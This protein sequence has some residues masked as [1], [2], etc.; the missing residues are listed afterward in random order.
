MPTTLAELL[1]F[2]HIEI[3]G[4]LD[5]KFS[6]WKLWRRVARGG[7]WNYLFWF[8]LAQYC[9]ARGN[10]LAKSFGK[11]I[12]RR[13]ARDFGVEIML[14][15]SIG[16]GLVL[17]HPTGIVVNA[18]CVIGRNFNLRQ[19]TTI[20]TTETEV[21]RHRPIVIGDNVDVGAHTCIVGSGL[22]IGSNVRIGAMSF[23]NKDIPDDCTYITVKE[24]RTIPRT[25][26]N[27]GEA[28]HP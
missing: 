25:A 17:G 12:N 9:H 10:G 15:V 26:G 8:R 18:G 6:Y 3:L 11:R 27:D 7:G 19:N 2:F 22:R 4:G 28:R 20:G 21:G 24:S 1:R 13:L 14:G 16:E 23:V 5:K